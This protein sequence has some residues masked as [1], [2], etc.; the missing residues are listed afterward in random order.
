[1][2]GVRPRG[3]VGLVVA[4]VVC[5]PVG[6]GAQVE[7]QHMRAD[8]RDIRMTVIADGIYQFMTM[9][10][11]YVRQVNTV[12]VVNDRDVL[13]F[14][15]GTRPTSA[16]LIL[17]QVRKITAKPVRYI[18]NS[19]WHPDHWSGNA[20]YADAFP[21]VEVIATRL[22]RDRMQ[23]TAEG[24]G[25]KFTAELGR[26]RAALAAE[27]GSG[28]GAD[29]SAVTAEV[30][31]QDQSDVN[32]Y[33]LFTEET[34]K[35]RRVLPTIVYT[36]SLSF[37][38]GGREFR[39][40][41]VTGDAEGTTVM[42]LPRERVLVTGD[43]VS[44]P[45]PFVPPGHAWASGGASQAGG[46]QCGSDRA[47]PWAGVPRQGVPQHGTGAAR[48]GGGWRGEGARERRADG[49][50]DAAG[51]DG[52][53]AAGRVHARGPGSRS[54]IPDAGQGSRRGGYDRGRRGVAPRWGPVAT[55]PERGDV[56]AD[57]AD[58]RTR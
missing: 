10:D 19:H 1:M 51:G 47:G 56:G 52:G 50:A 28:K 27:Q 35:L 3:L 39:F 21:E 49:R 5:W 13:V 26:R 4:A 20:V 53:G 17:A 30:L 14:D 58:R 45:I 22:T 12:V 9:R 57:L 16:R 31:K 32:E 18:V 42:Y 48:R 33:A 25:P 34:V 55:G 44:Y 29:G 15:T 37:F 7:Y 2:R 6:S 36:D 24:W 46:S 38:H 8:G 54:A 43:A 41:S 23:R 11:S 40:M